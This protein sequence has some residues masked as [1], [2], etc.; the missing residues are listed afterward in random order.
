MFNL[1]NMH[2]MDYVLLSIIIFLIFEAIFVHTESLIWMVIWLVIIYLARQHYY[3]PSGRMFF[4]IGVIAFGITVINTITF[5][6]VLFAALVMFVLHW[7]QKNQRTNYHQVQ[8]PIDPQLKQKKV[9][10]TNK[11]FGRQQ[12]QGPAYEWNDINMQ[13][14]AGETIIDLTYTVL[15]KGE[16]LIIARHLFGTVKIIVPFDVEV[17]IHH[18]VLFGA[19]DILNHRDEAITNRVIH[20]QTE[21]YQEANQK[22]KIVTSMI[23]GKIEVTRE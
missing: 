4:W 3:R 2:V 9:L 14:I 11:W 23:A 5:Q 6:I 13:A 7:Y 21:A 16:P 15:P 12:T 8:F 17:S 22:V 19:V 18:S 20:L 1:K 10:F